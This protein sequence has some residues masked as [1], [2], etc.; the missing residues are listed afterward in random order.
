[1]TILDTEKQFSALLKEMKTDHKEQIGD[2]YPDESGYCEATEF[3]DEDA[4][5]ILDNKL[6]PL[7]A[8]NIFKNSGL[9]YLDNCQFQIL[10]HNNLEKACSYYNLSSAYSYLT[11]LVYVIQ[12]SCED[13][14]D[15]KLL[16]DTF[17]KLICSSLISGWENEYK[18]MNEWAIES[19]DYGRNYDDDGF[20]DIKFMATGANFCISSWFLLDL[21]CKA[22]ER[23]YNMDN[24]EYPNVMVPYD[25]VLEEWDTTDIQK[26][27]QL[28]YAMS[29][30]HLTQT[31]QEKVDK[32]YFAFSSPNFWFYAHEILAWLKLREIKGLKNPK[33]YSHPLMNTPIAEFFLNLKTPLEKPKNLPYAKVLLEKL[34]E[35]C[36]NT[37]VPVWVYNKSS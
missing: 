19:I 7:Y 33:K 20:L 25:K 36:P 21:Y 11:V 27:D 12:F 4:Q 15:D 6:T 16:Q 34:K 18:K 29:E 23:N 3:W 26:V 32:D 14:G 24:A 31:E 37:Q 35:K 5:E 9:F 1:M 30:Y 13:A 17:Y 22:Y 8:G 2:R 28:V 10:K